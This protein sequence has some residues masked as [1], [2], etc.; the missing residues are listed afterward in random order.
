MVTVMKNMF[1]QSNQHQQQI[2]VTAILPTPT[3]TRLHSEELASTASATQSESDADALAASMRRTNLATADSSKKQK[4]DNPMYLENDHSR[5]SSP[6]G[7]Q[8]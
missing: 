7:E 1:Q 6:P 8:Q 5:L 3:A 2:P 4:S